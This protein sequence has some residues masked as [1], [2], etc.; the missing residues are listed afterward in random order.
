M[1]D[2][3]KRLPPSPRV[4]ERPCR[5][6]GCQGRARGLSPCCTTC[7]RKVKLRGHI[8]QRQVKARDTKQ[9]GIR[10]RRVLGMFTDAERAALKEYCERG[11]ARLQA[12]AM[13]VLGKQPEPEQKTKFWKVA[14]MQLQKVSG[15]DPLAFYVY[16]ASLFLIRKE[17][18]RYFED[19]QSFR[20]CFARKTIR[21]H[22]YRMED[23][24][25]WAIPH[26]RLKNVY[27][28]WSVPTSLIL[29]ELLSISALPFAQKLI[30]SLAKAEQ[31]DKTLDDGLQGLF[32]V[33]DGRLD[34]LAANPTTL[35][36][37]RILQRKDV[38][39][40]LQRLRGKTP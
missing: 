8:N 1:R 25:T 17:D 30:S 37:K 7:R 6:N 12:T 26:S 15:A 18:P 14:A 4:S 24:K 19:A 39:R 9:A 20:V 36:L 35:R 5:S 22:C 33:V 29:Y 21:L 16:M 40:D 34:I 31:V 2:P 23:R 3:L 10:L 11:M 38:W 13:Q 28:I 27:Y 32:A